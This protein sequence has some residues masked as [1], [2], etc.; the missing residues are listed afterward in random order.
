MRQALEKIFQHPNADKDILLRAI[1]YRNAL[2]HTQAFASDPLPPFWEIFNHPR[3]QDEVLGAAALAIAATPPSRRSEVSAQ[4]VPALQALLKDPRAMDFAKSSARLAL[5]VMVPASNAHP[6]SPVA[7]SVSHVNYIDDVSPRERELAKALFE[8]L[9]QEALRLRSNTHRLGEINGSIRHRVLFGGLLDDCLLRQVLEIFDLASQGARVSDTWITFPLAATYFSSGAGIDAF[10][11]LLPD[12]LALFSDEKMLFGFSAQPQTT[13]QWR[14]P[15]GPSLRVLIVKDG[16]I[17]RE[18]NPGGIHTIYLNFLTTKEQAQKLLYPPTV[19]AA[20]RASEEERVVRPPSAGAS[21][22]EEGLFARAV[23]QLDLSKPADVEVLH[24]ILDSLREIPPDALRRAPVAQLDVSLEPLRQRAQEL[25][26]RPPGDE[27]VVL[28]G[29]ITGP[30]RDAYQRIDDALLGNPQNNPWPSSAERLLVLQELMSHNPDI[31]Y[32]IEKAAGSSPLLSLDGGVLQLSPSYDAAVT[33]DIREAVGALEGK[34]VERQ[35]AAG[36]AFLVAMADGGFASRVKAAVQQI[37]TNDPET[38]Q[39]VE[40]ILQFIQE[41]ESDSIDVH[42]L[43]PAPR[44]SEEE[45]VVRPPSAGASGLEEKGVAEIVAVAEAAASKAAEDAGTTWEQD[46]AH[47]AVFDASSLEDQR[48][49]AMVGSFNL[50]S[51]HILIWGTSPTVE[52]IRTQ[53]KGIE[54]AQTLEEFEAWVRRFYQDHGTLGVVFFGPKARAKVLQDKMEALRN[55]E[56][57][58]LGFV[59]DDRFTEDFLLRMFVAFSVYPWEVASDVARQLSA[60]LEEEKLL[61]A[62]A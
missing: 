15:I 36:P 10:K 51:K 53:N 23:R 49:A 42:K 57:M 41:L 33:R 24:T 61:G 54:V 45:R 21:G 18:I 17:I 4:A 34:I 13:Q 12:A 2:V 25:Y 11:Y 30:L 3:A 19:A 27:N 40:T 47:A 59:Q 56:G 39:L 44:A 32:L 58:S 22:L 60:G 50:F 16:E 14:I 38:Q 9:P 6:S 43:P 62:G 46:N 29:W 52:A 55:S 5:K 26:Q 8:G 31:A 20:P 28:I 1:T 48:I 7:P 35:P 37:Q